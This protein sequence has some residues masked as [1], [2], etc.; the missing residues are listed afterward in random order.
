MVTSAPF[1]NWWHDAYWLDVRILSPPHSVLAAGMFFLVFGGLLQVLSLQNRAAAEGGTAG[2]WLF[3]FAGGI[4]LCLA[5]IMIMERTFPNSQ[6][7]VQFLTTSLLTFPFFIFLIARSA[8]VPM[9]A[10]TVAAIYM[11][12]MGTAVWVLPLF[13]GTPR[14]AP[15][16]HPVTHMVPPAFPLLA[17][18]AGAGH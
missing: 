6:H 16:F 4:L 13:P 8:R 14:L 11:A 10:T 12:L 5:S 9:P 15:I 3:V 2:R 7:G 18:G 1:D 17:G